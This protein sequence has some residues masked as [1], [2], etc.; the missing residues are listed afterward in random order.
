MCVCV[1]VCVWCVYVKRERERESACVP[2][3]AGGGGGD[4][5]FICFFVVVCFCFWSFV[6]LMRFWDLFVVTVVVAC[7]LLCFWVFSCPP[8]PKQW[9]P[10]PFVF[11]EQ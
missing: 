4:Y 1:C 6:V 2:A 7:F 10:L 8:S 9:S 5:G 3:C 11:D